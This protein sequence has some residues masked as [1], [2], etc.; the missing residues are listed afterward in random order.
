MVTRWTCRKPN[1]LCLGDMTLKPTHLIVDLVCP[2]GLDDVRNIETFMRR[3]I[4]VTGLTIVHFHIQE[5]SNGTEFGPGITGIVLLSESHMVVHTAPERKTLNLDLF[6]RRTF[7][8]S[9]L[10]IEI[11]RALGITARKR[12]AVL[13]R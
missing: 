13:T 10:E 5:F 8:E 12:W 7:D 3:A 6:S 9:D 1:R 11:V 4:E 2:R